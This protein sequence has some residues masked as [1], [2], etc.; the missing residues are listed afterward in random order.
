[1]EVMASLKQETGQKTLPKISLVVLGEDT[2]S[3][4][5]QEMPTTPVTLETSCGFL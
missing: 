1:M 2:G 5:L 3:L 4:T